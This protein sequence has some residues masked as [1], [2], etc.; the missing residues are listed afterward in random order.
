MLYVD[1]SYFDQEYFDRC[2]ALFEQH[3]IIGQCKGKRITV[4]LDDP[5]F[6]VAL[7]LF[8]K[9]QG[10][11]VF[12][13]PADT[14]IEAARRRARRSASHYLLFGKKGEAALAS[15]E[16]MD[17]CGEESKAVL[18]QMSS[19][20]T[21]EPKIIER[22]WIS[23]D[24]EI[25]SYIQHFSSANEMTPIV[26]C[27]VNHSY[28]LICGVLV[29]LKRGVR[30]LI[31]RNLNPKYII[32]KLREATKPIL[33]SSP[34]LIATI[35]MRVSEEKP[36]YAV[37]TSGTIMQKTWFENI[38]KKVVHLYQQ[39]GCSEA[40][41]I[42]LGED[43]SEA[44]DLGKP[45]PHVDLIAGNS[46]KEP[47]EIVVS[48]NAENSR[49]TVHTRDLG[50]LDENGNLH[51]VS[52]LDDMIN[53]A[54]FNVYPG[55]VEEVVLEIPQVTDAVVFK[56][57]HSF[58]GDQVCLNYVSAI[59][60]PE[61]QIREWCARRLAS[62]QVPMNITHVD[63]IPKLPNGKVSRKALAEMAPA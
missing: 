33:Y 48:V 23:I 34:T 62:H 19:G 31:I 14:P 3:S 26:A 54:G 61:Q 2:F 41:C 28:G 52:R 36:I 35:T 17:G 12:P 40:G 49:S 29:A 55:E 57:R 43:I 30:P 9:N 5:A 18:V 38:S 58:G 20:T 56:R 13:L 44:N 39:Y 42:A 22:S 59:A 60:L 15:I 63:A 1:D 8:L 11:S 46:V 45:L 47:A 24:T 21:G 32:R 4:C 10:A 50:Y 6:W 16:I 51:F 53:V 25:K 37:M 27:P 7:C